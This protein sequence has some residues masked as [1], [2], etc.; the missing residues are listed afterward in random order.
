MEELKEFG[1][2][3]FKVKHAIEQNVIRLEG[4]D[5]MNRIVANLPSYL[6]NSWSSKYADTF[7]LKFSFLH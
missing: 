7:I 6:R 3:L 5:P 4:E 2:Y 1:F